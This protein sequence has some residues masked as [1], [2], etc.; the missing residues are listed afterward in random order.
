ASSGVARQV[1]Q[2]AQGAGASRAA[3]G[4]ASRTETA[5]AARVFRGSAVRGDEVANLLLQHGQRH[6]P[7][8]QYGVV[9]RAF[10]E[11]RTELGLRLAPQLADLQL[12]HLVAEGL[13]GPGDVA[14]GL[15]PHL[16]Q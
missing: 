15:R 9:E 13:A 3:E 1:T 14:V 16:V 7:I 5:A 8:R 6:G 11:P 4:T 10:V 12:A 2:A